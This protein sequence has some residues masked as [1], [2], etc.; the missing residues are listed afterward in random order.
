MKKQIENIF[1]K[2]KEEKKEIQN[3]FPII[4]DIREKHSLVYSY[5][6]GMN[7]NAKF[8]KL[9]IGD[10]LVGDVVIERKSFSDFQ[11]SMMDKRLLSQLVE[12]KKYPK[13]FLMLEGFLFDYS[14]ARIH[15]NAIRGMILSCVLDFGIPIIYTKNEEDSAKMLLVLAKRLEKEKKDISLRYKKSEMSFEEQKQF[16]LEGFHGIGP[17]TAKALIEKFK[18]LEK[19]FNCSR[20]KLAKTELF[21]EK[22]LENFKRLLEN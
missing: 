10:F 5:L 12:L 13:C 8:E 15:E 6:V 14:N 22:K 21:D 2:S 3:K 4:V 9:D 16:I 20:E 19:I 1:S 18:T 7:V 17:T 11:S